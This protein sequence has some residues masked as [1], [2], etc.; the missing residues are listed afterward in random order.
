MFQTKICSWVLETLCI[1]FKH[2]DAITNSTNMMFK[3]KQWKCFYY[4]MLCKQWISVWCIS[5][6]CY[7]VM[8]FDDLNSTSKGLITGFPWKMLSDWPSSEIGFAVPALVGYD[9]LVEKVNLPSWLKICIMMWSRK[10]LAL[11]RSLPN[12]YRLIKYGLTNMLL[13]TILF[14]WSWENYLFKCIMKS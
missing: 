13:T 1:W 7:W 12:K 4:E 14:Y 11:W 3:E 5:M 8:S 10:Y 9:Q 6:K 2:I